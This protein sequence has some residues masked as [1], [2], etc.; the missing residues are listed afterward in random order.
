[1]QVPVLDW[2]RARKRVEAF[3]SSGAPYCLAEV[4]LHE[5]FAHGLTPETVPLCVMAV[6]SFWNANVDKEPGALNDLCERTVANLHE[7]KK[8]VEIVRAV[9]LS[10]D[11]SGVSMIVSGARHLLPRFLKA[12]H[13][14][15]TNY[16]FASKFLH[17]CCPS[18]LPIV[19]NLSV[20]TINRL[21]GR[22]VIWVPN[23]NTPTTEER[24]VHSYE[25]VIRFYNEALGQ[26]DDSGRMALVEHDLDTQPEGFRKRNTTVRILDKWLWMEQKQPQP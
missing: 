26:L 14:K 19:D 17:W 9:S 22:G 11:S 24:C 12:P 21:M 4:A 10:A 23:A 1:M 25:R 2:D 7:I 6:N 20:K 16:S 3:N 13:A 15:R 8:Q 5:A 18:S